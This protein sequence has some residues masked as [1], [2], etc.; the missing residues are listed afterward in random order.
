MKWASLTAK[1]GKI[2][3]LQRKKFGG[4]DSYSHNPITLTKYFFVF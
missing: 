3:R 1:N 4:I 2:M